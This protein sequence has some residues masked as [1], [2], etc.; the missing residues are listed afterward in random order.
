MTKVKVPANVTEVR[1]FLGLV[2]YCSQFI[3]T[4]AE[5]T[6]PLRKLTEKNTVFKWSNEHQYSFK[7]WHIVY[8]MQKQKL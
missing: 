8:Q 6:E 2:N 4:Y 3:A 5:L 1:S 7:K